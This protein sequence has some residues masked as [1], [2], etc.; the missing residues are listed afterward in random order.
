[1][2]ESQAPDEKTLVDDVEGVVP[3]PGI[4][5]GRCDV[6]LAQ[7]NVRVLGKQIG[8]DVDTVE[9]ELDLWIDGLE[10]FE[11]GSFFIVNEQLW[12]YSGLM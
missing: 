4:G 6:V 1:L 7:V 3:S 9:I 10:I 5:E 2:G 8:S 12:S 11:P